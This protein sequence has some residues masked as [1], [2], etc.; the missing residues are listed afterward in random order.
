MDFQSIVEVPGGVLIKNLENFEL[1]H[2]FDCGQCFR[3]NKEDNGNYIGVAFGRV[4]EAEQIGLDIMLYNTSVEEFYKIWLNYFDLDKDYSKIKNQLS[5]DELLKSD[6]IGRDYLKIDA[7]GSI[8]PASKQTVENGQ[9]F[10]FQDG[11][12]VYKYAVSGMADV[13]EKIMLRNN[14]TNDDVNW[15]IAHQ[16]NKR[17]IDATAN[18]MGIEE[19]KVLINIHRYGNT[20]SATL[21]LLLSDFESKFKK[22]DIYIMTTYVL[23]QS[24]IVVG[25]L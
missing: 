14:L 10:V 22:G 20:T 12:T 19:D 18:R 7:G 4:L 6:G 13:S 8:L 24:L 23:A 25:Y 16:A 3:W 11:K 2:I 1:K 5:E 15:L 9:H 17:I 21:P